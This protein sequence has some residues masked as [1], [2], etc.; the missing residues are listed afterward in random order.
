MNWFIFFTTLS[1]AAPFLFAGAPVL[2]WKGANPDSA[3]D[4]VRQ[5]LD[6]HGNLYVVCGTSGD[7]N[8]NI[9]LVSFDPNGTQ[10]WSQSFDS[11]YYDEP[12]ALGLDGSGNVYVAGYARPDRDFV[13]L[14]YS[15][16]GDLFW[17]R[18]FGTPVDAEIATDAVVDRSGNI[19]VT[20]TESAGGIGL[21]RA[22]MVTW[23][24]EGEQVLLHRYPGPYSFPSGLAVDSRGLVSVG[25]LFPWENAIYI[26][27]D[28]FDGWAPIVLRHDRQDNLFGAF[29]QDS[30]L[31]LIK[32][33]SDG[34]PLWRREQSI[35]GSSQYSLRTDSNGDLIVMESHHQDDGSYTRLS[36]HTGKASA[37]WSF[38]IT[39]VFASLEAFAVGRNDEIILGVVESDW[40]RSRIMGLSKQGKVEWTIPAPGRTVAAVSADLAGNFY[41]TGGGVVARYSNRR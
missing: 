41:V 37:R 24:S 27:N 18:S 36:K 35:G 13:V 15:S 20:G 29:T 1:L 25:L 30:K 28:R 22:V 40:S 5:A 38:T 33:N 32:Y 19:S 10:R 23:N 6:S 21:Q 8:A 26:N 11:G 3:I 34:L 2:R 9:S 4:I 14:K 39:N 17:T 12:R 7:A 31:V 16:T